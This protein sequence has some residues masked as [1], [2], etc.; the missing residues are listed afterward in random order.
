MTLRQRIIELRLSGVSSDRT[1]V[2]SARCRDRQ[3][4]A[5]EPGR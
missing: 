4:V 2:G 3:V 1:D 5:A